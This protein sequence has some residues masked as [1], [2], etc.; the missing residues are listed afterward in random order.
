MPKTWEKY[1]D[2]TDKA[3]HLMKDAAEEAGFDFTDEAYEKLS[4]LAQDLAANPTSE[5]DPE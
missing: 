5:V 3:F 2:A 1:T 4:L